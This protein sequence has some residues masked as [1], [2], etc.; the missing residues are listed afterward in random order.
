MQLFIKLITNHEF[1]IL[2]SSTV[3]ASAT[4]ILLQFIGQFVSDRRRKL[5][6]VSYFIDVAFRMLFSSLTMKKHT[7]IPHI[8]AT[9]KIIAG[10]RELLKTMFLADEF[11]VLTDE[12]FQPHNL[13]EDFN[14]L[15]GIDNMN[16]VQMYEFLFYSSKNV[17]T[18]KC[19]NNFVIKNLKSHLIFTQK[20]SEE[21]TDILNTYW[22]Y[23]SKLE[24]EED[25]IIFHVL[26]SMVPEVKKYISEPQF[27]FFS[28]QSVNH[29][30][31]AINKISLEY[32]DVLCDENEM[33]KV[34]TGG[35]QKLV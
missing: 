29:M 31:M 17:G 2:F 12:P 23:L 30:I 25:R 26:Y 15:I 9:K 22:D 10:D 35:I 24:H 4:M 33:K 16:L 3:V 20:S 7:I 19:F 13:S 1:L 6:A 8:T 11:D 14:V 21:Q 34:L 32:R 18:Q 5:Y 28:K 27:I